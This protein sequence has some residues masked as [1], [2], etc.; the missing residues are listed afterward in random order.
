MERLLENLMSNAPKLVAAAGKNR[1]T[2]SALGILAVCTVVIV[3]F[4]TNPGA[5]QTV[6][7]DSVVMGQVS[8]N[9]RI[10]DRSVVIGA[11]DTH[12]NT[13]LT[14]PMAVGTG[15]CA[16]PR[17]IAIGAYAGAGACPTPSAPPVRST[18]QP[19]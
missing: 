5:S 1:L 16:G 6:G 8:P 17:S 14:Q 15:A 9:A 13:I 10:G 18:D 2:L 11:T 3:Y 4:L 12:G 7:N 19:K